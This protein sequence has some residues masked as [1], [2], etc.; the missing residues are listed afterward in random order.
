MAYILTLRKSFSSKNINGYVDTVYR[1][2]KLS[3]RQAAQEFGEDRIGDKIKEALKKKPEQ[4]FTFIH[5]VEPTEV[6]SEHTDNRRHDTATF[7]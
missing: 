6:T 1:R 7:P 5:A 2:Y 4:Q 3:A